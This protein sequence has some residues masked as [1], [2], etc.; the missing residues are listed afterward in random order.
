MIFYFVIFCVAGF[1]IGIL[2]KNFKVAM[3]VIALI[4]LCWAFVYGPW[5][6]ATFVELMVGYAVAKVVAKEMS[7]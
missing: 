4:S 5:A 7:K 2:L 1:I 6:L 3:L